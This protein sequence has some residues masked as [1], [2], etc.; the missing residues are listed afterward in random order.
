[1]TRTPKIVV[2]SAHSHQIREFHVNARLSN[3]V[4]R[5]SQ[6]RPESEETRALMG[7]EPLSESEAM[8]ACDLHA[9]DGI[10]EVSFDTY[11]LRLRIALAFDWDEVQP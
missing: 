5:E 1:M 4:Y 10:T 3:T 8:F 7:R 9:I 6:G 11:S 2:M